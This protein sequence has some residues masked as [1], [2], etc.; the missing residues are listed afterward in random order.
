[1]LPGL[2]P[3][4]GGEHV[5]AVDTAV[6]DVLPGAPMLGDLA[7]LEPENVEYGRASTSRR[8]YEVGVHHE[9]FNACRRRRARRR[10]P[11]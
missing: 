7:T 2:R 4:G 11:R 8:Q 6:G 3:T 10:D 9:F 5:V 1:M